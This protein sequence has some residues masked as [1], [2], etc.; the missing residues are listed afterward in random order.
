[1]TN[2][3]FR[4]CSTCQ[5]RKK[6]CLLLNLPLTPHPRSAN[7]QRPTISYLKSCYWVFWCFLDLTD[8]TLAD[9]RHTYF[10]L[11]LFNILLRL[12][13]GKRPGARGLMMAGPPGAYM[14]I[15]TLDTGQYYKQSPLPGCP[16]SNSN[17]TPPPIQGTRAKQELASF[18]WKLGF[19]VWI[20]TLPEAQQTQAIEFETWIIPSSPIWFSWD[21]VQN[22]VQC[23]WRWRI[24]IQDALWTNVWNSVQ[25]LLAGI[26][27]LNRSPESSFSMRSSIVIQNPR[28]LLLLLRHQIIQANV[29]RFLPLNI[30]CHP[31]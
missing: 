5:V 3:T 12:D 17:T 31:H 27:A 10:I 9:W 26:E 19:Q 4:V 16:P 18:G 7:D 28:F 15:W 20:K 6:F 30:R 13:Q 24:K 8:V 1:M 21:L 22:C 25:M 11:L 2:N 29:P 23:W 14:H